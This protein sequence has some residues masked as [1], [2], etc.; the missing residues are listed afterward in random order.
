MANPAVPVPSQ[1]P[2]SRVMVFIDGA[3]LFNSVK[4]R[5]GYREPNADIAKLAKAVVSL[6]PK[7]T[8]TAIFYY[9]GV[10]SQEHDAKN[11][12]WWDRKITAMGKLG[13][14][15]IRRK[16]KPRDLNIEISGVV[17]HK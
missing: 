2:L 12:D 10:A 3:N 17:H 15:T 6:R 8:T 5:F 4:R 7:R 9:I 11:H 13:V 1:I 14:K 16:L